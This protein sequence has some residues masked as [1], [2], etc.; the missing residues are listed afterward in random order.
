[1]K[2]KS[3]TSFIIFVF[4]VLLPAFSFAQEEISIDIAPSV[5]NLSNNGIVVTVHTDIP[6]SDVASESLFLDG[7]EIQSYKAD[8]QGF[9]VAKFSIDA[10][11]E[12]VK[13]DVNLNH[14]FV[15]NGE[16]IDESTFS[17]TADVLI[18]DSSMDKSGK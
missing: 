16:L 3:I 13:D 8:S 2:S 14:T 17:G 18:I 4:L 6:Y 11:K 1:M 15:L 7:V 10:I 5:L 9:F 12:V